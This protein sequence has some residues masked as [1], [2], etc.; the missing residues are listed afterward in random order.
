MQVFKKIC[1]ENNMIS[2]PGKCFEYMQEF[3]EDKKQIS[4]FDL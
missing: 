2:D 3:P 4:I 1:K